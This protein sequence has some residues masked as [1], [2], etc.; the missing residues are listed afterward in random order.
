MRT[1]WTLCLALAFLTVP[2]VLAADEAPT[3]PS[4][5][6]PSEAWRTINME[7][8]KIPYAKRADHVKAEALAYLKQFGATGSMAL[9]QEALSLGFIQRGAQQWSQ[10][11]ATFRSVWANAENL[12]TLRDQ[13]AMQEAGLLGTKD[14]R[15]ALGSAGCMKAIE[16]LSAYSADL[17]TGARLTM[18]SNIESNIANVLA[19]MEHKQRA[20]DLRI[21]VV[22]RDPMMAS[23]LYRSLVAG[24]LGKTHALD[25]YDGVRSEVRPLL[26]L[27]AAQQ[28]KAIEMTEAKQK[29]AMAN[30]LENSPD[31]VDENGKLKAKPANKRSMLERV[32]YNAGRQ[33]ASAKS[34][35]TRIEKAGAPFA[36]LG[37][38]APDWTLEHA[39][40]ELKGLGDLKGKVV[41]LD[42]WATWCPW[43]IK[44]FPAIRDLLRDYEKQ[45]LVVVGV[46]ASAGTVY[47]ARYDLDDDL[48][49]KVVPGKRATPA[50]RLA[51]GTQKPNGETLFSAEDY[52]A[53]E[54]EVIKTFISNHKMN[55]PVVMI[56]KTEPAPKYALAGWPHAVVIDREGRVRYFKS[57]ALL[58]DRVDAVKKFR[59][60]LE[61]LLAEKAK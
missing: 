21:A 25:G 52:P 55:W 1:A 16:S 36:M 53:K 20:H 40:G 61:D 37:K 60:L 12:E 45:G 15:D 35:L 58:R 44:S 7:G 18:R 4:V 5:T 8:R 50:A 11:A 57:G 42:F 6:K 56:D 49:D 34:Y 32:A 3:T 48:L 2:S 13:G 30:L 47:E 31:S 33:L 43:C 51:R 29:Q 17:G 19:A 28:A 24:L 26:D 59:A 41:V 22:T 23:R 38:P 9:G 14:L 54:L 27:L 10:A 46:T 39:F